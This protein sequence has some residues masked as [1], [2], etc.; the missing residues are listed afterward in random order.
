MIGHF[1]AFIV[2]ILN[3]LV[4]YDGFQILM[5]CVAVFGAFALTRALT[6]RKRE[7]GGGAQ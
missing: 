7:R 6:R 2:Q 3:Y 4:E 1:G 5:G